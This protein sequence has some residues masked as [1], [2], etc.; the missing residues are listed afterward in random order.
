MDGNTLESVTFVRLCFDVLGFVS[1]RSVMFWNVSLSLVNLMMGLLL[2]SMGPSHG[3]GFALFT[4][5]WHG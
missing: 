3:M 4:M 2:M 1:F 5:K